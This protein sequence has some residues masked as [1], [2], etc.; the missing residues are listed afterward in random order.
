[1]EE[2]SEQFDP[3]LDGS[4]GS[5]GN[6]EGQEFTM[7]P[8]PRG[9]PGRERQKISIPNDM[10]KELEI[11]NDME[12]SDTKMMDAVRQLVAQ[13]AKQMKQFQ[14]FTVENMKQSKDVK[15]KLEAN[16]RKLEDTS[17]TLAQRT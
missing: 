11:L 2:L 14:N 17:H 8:G 15:I 1:M 5:R 12:I 3:Q 10:V 13:H 16:V 4:R 7:S 9:E 6:A